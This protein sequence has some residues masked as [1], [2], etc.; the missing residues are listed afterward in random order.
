MTDSV[1]ISLLDSGP[2]SLPISIIGH[3]REE[4]GPVSPVSPGSADGGKKKFIWN[5]KVITR[6]SK[7]ALKVVTQMQ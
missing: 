7:Q 2:S 3:Q 1:D 5:I 4:G 6:T